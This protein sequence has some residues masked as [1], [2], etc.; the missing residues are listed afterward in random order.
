MSGEPGDQFGT[1]VLALRL[2]GVE[3]GH[4][5]R[6]GGCQ[7]DVDTAKTRLAL[8]AAV[9]DGHDV[10]LVEMDGLVRGRGSLGPAEIRYF[11]ARA[12]GVQATLPEISEIGADLVS[13]LVGVVL[14]VRLPVR[15]DDVRRHRDG[16]L[17]GPVRFQLG[18]VRAEEIA[19]A[20]QKVERA[21]LLVDGL[22]FGEQELEVALHVPANEDFLLVAH[23]RR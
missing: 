6:P 15:A 17:A 16:P 10:V 20:Q 8:Q 11:E 22:R 18:V 9:P 14:Q 5:F 13:V 2:V 21:A 4:V 3:I 1:L 12:G 7:Q 23:L 19:D